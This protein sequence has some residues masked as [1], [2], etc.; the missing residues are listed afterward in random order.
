MNKK[1]IA[2][3][4]IACFVGLALLPRA[5][6]Q[7]DVA[8]AV[9]VR[10]PMTNIS[11]IDLRK[12]FSGEKRTWPGGLPIQ[13]IVRA[14]GCHER[15]ALLQL[16]NMTEGEYKQHW[17]SLVFRGEADAPPAVVPSSGMQREAA[18]AFPGSVTL[19]ESSAV[20]SGMKVIKVDGLLPGA[21]G[22]PLH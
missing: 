8:V 7:V 11:L 22:Y 18:V 4:C 17:T 6:A 21:S 16:L 1:L 9:S 5:S 15:Q 3:W 13:L 19:V 2:A 20:R 14:P 12:I 10:N